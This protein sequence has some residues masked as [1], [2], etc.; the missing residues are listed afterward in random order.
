MG[1]KG[2]RRREKNYRAAH[3]GASLLP[4][5]P[6]ASSVDAL[7][8][9]LR[10]LMSLTAGTAKF[11]KEVEQRRKNGEKKPRLTDEKKPDSKETKGRVVSLEE[12]EDNFD[13]EKFNEGQNLV[14]DNDSSINKKKKKKRKR[15]QVNDLRFEET[16]EML[17]IGSKRKDR[18]KKYLEE[19]KKKKKKAKTGDTLEF[20]QRE[21]IAFGDVV[22]APPKLATVPKAF[23]SAQDASKE[24][25]RLKAV[26][27]Y[28]QRKGWVS[29][30]GINLPPPVT[31]EPEV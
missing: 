9:K 26:D 14:P 22:E 2:Q 3:G 29:R 6:K 12:E 16:A 30:P 18:K 5:P 20:Q 28:R 17:G 1:G 4:P 19:R 31:A 25:L 8:S 21:K 23:K 13:E 24:R 27:A 7:P 15:N 11:S 10:Q